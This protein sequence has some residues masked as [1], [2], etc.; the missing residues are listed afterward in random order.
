MTGQIADHFAQ[1]KILATDEFLEGTT[2]CDRGYPDVG[3]LLGSQF[4]SGLRQIVE[5]TFQKK[6]PG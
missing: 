4:T 6:L 1:R 2:P 3:R 5:R